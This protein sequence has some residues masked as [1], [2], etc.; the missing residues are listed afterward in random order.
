MDSWTPATHLSDRQMQHQPERMAASRDATGLRG[1]EERSG[2]ELEE[3][4]VYPRRA[5]WAEDAEQAE[6]ISRDAETGSYDK[7]SERLRES[8][9]EQ[10]QQEGHRVSRGNG[11]EELQLNVSPPDEP[12]DER[13]ENLPGPSRRDGRR[14]VFAGAENGVGPRDGGQEQGGERGNQ[15]R[16][17]EYLDSK[18]GDE[19]RRDAGRFSQTNDR[20]V[21][22]RDGECDYQQDEWKPPKVAGQPSSFTQDSES[23]LNEYGQRHQEPKQ[24]RDGSSSSDSPEIHGA[25]KYSPHEPSSQESTPADDAGERKWR[26]DASHSRLR[27][28]MF[29]GGVSGEDLR[30]GEQDSWH[31]VASTTPGIEYLSGSGV[32][33]SDLH[34]DRRKHSNNEV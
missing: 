9:S 24:P 27:A 23:S 31:D 1:K 21:Y 19:Q 32:A 22:R 2:E 18:K 30:R 34:R 4:P 15:R 13:N 6:D 12:R 28:E 20:P 8:S 16:I 17:A 3:G 29:S 7:T 10:R 26:K 5:P 14:V 25:L 33:K 11:N